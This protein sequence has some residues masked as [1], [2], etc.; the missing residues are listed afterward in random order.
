MQNRNHPTFQQYAALPYLPHYKRGAGKKCKLVRNQGK[1]IKK[2]PPSTPP[3]KTREKEA[4]AKNKGTQPLIISPLFRFGKNE[5]EVIP[6]NRSI[7]AEI[8]FFFIF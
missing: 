6:L 3:T 7:S 8:Y 1:N 4:E 2:F 5:K